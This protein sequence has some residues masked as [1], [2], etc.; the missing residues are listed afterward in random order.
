MNN[1]SALMYNIQNLYGSIAG[2]NNKILELENQI[3]KQKTS[4]T[5]SVSVMNTSEVE[6]KV[7]KLVNTVDVMQKQYSHLETQMSE[8]Q[9]MIA[10]LKVSESG[11]TSDSHVNEDI[12]KHD[13]IE[14]PDALQVT[15]P[16]EVFEMVPAK[17][18][19]G[20]R[21]KRNS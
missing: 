20:G 7:V 9:K 17:P 16:E 14:A 6:N 19:G 18:K 10:E 5:T 2:I 4:P 8:L 15:P 11:T 1:Y 3:F 12:Q 13:F 21:K